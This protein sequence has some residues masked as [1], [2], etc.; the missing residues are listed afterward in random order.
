MGAAQALLEVLELEP[1]ETGFLAR[2]LATGTDVVFGGQLLAQ[3]VVAA[4]R[5]VPAQEVKTLHGV[6]AR[7][8]R[9]DAPLE[10]DVIPFHTG[11][12]L[13]SLTIV[14]RQG[15]RRCAHFTV[16]MSA[17]ESDLV[18]HAARM[19]EVG[20]PDAAAERP[21]SLLA[22]GELRVVGDVD[23][24]DPDRVGPAEYAIWFR[25]PGLP[26]QLSIHQALLADATDGHLIGTAMRPHP[27]VGQA[28]AH[29][30]I[31]TGVVGHTLSFHDPIDLDEWHLI[32]H[33]S[34]W[35][36]RGRAHGRAHVFRQDGRLVAS[37]VQDAILRS[38]GMGGDSAR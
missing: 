34:P 12:T 11:R 22:P 4:A 10:F 15:D 36:G 32:A 20:E 14:A 23:V 13:S 7:A 24:M 16:L 37:F 31:Q 19:P 6:F 2:S 29:Q 38:P 9:P 28:M 5:T 33:E 8:A 27:G 1:S 3:A 26:K 30:S 18:R 25:S 17:S 35:A 21:A